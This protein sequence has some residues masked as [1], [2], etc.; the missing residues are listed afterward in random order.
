MKYSTL[1]EQPNIYPSTESYTQDTENIIVNGRIDGNTVTFPKTDISNIKVYK[2]IS[3][4]FLVNIRD[5]IWTSQEFYD[6]LKSALDE[7]NPY[8]NINNV[9]SV[10]IDNEVLT[11]ELN[12]FKP[13]E[14]RAEVKV[15]DNI[16]TVEKVLKH[17]DWVISSQRELRDASLI[18]SWTTTTSADL[19]RSVQDTEPI[20]SI[21][22]LDEEPVIEEEPKDFEVKTEEDSKK[23]ESVITNDVVTPNKEYNVSS[24][25]EPR[26]GLNPT[27]TSNGN[28]PTSE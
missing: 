25:V 13:N 17:I 6:D 9:P 4:R 14:E 26:F 1:S 23:E 15:I 18:G 12:K 20:E 5:E 28:F 21:D 3:I 2:E 24:D 19:G 16:N 7:N 8:F 27:R 11:N 22:T 10:N